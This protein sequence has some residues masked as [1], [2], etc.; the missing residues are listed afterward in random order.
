MYIVYL[1]GGLVNHTAIKRSTVMHIR[2]LSSYFR[3]C[4]T[5]RMILL[6]VF[7]LSHSYD[8]NQESIIN[9]LLL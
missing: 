9:G 7:K 4:S 3:S 6:H 2:S 5:M 8:Y 1:S